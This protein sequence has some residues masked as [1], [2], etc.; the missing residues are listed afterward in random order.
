[1]SRVFYCHNDN[2]VLRKYFSVSLQSL[3]SCITVESSEFQCPFSVFSQCLSPVSVSHLGKI[4]IILL[5][6]LI[7]VALFNQHTLFCEL[8]FESF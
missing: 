5:D 1:M 2:N 7:F 3:Y 8:L 4:N 6:R